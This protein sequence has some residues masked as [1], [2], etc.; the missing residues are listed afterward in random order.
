[1]PVQG[2]SHRLLDGLGEGVHNGV[3]SES[4]V[5]TDRALLSDAATP[6][7]KAGYRIESQASG[8]MVLVAS[9][10]PVP[11]GLMIILSIV[12]LGLWIPIWVLLFSL[13]RVNRRTLTI[14]D[15]DV[16][17]TKSWRTH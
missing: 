6:W 14:V 16:V 9:P 10:I 1:M 3:M 5:I 17:T 8:V 4:A 13:P 2:A 11:V 7:L 15:G 12:T